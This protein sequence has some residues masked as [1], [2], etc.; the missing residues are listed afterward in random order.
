M[1]LKDF[2]MTSPTPNE[3]HDWVNQYSDMA[4]VDF[5][6]YNRGLEPTELMIA[7]ASKVRNP[8]SPPQN[9]TATKYGDHLIEATTII[10]DDEYNK[11]EVSGVSLGKDG[12]DYSVSVI[13]NSGTNNVTMGVTLNSNTIEI[14]LGTNSSG[15]LSTSIINENFI[16]NYDTFEDLVYSNI[17]YDTEVVTETDNT[18]TYTRGTD[19]EMDY[20]NGKIKVLSDSEMA[21][22]T[23]YAIDYYYSENQGYNIAQEVENVLADFT[24]DVYYDGRGLIDTAETKDLIGGKTGTETKYYELTCIDKSGETTSSTTISVDNCLEQFTSE[25]YV[26]LNWES[27]DRAEE[28]GV[29]G[30]T[31][32]LKE[33]LT[34]VDTNTYADK[35][36]DHIGGIPPEYNTTD[37]KVRLWHGS[38]EQETVLEFANRK[39][40]MSADSKLIYYLNSKDVD[41][42]AFGAEG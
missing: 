32:S 1:A 23:G 42:V 20:I 9:I 19:Y 29:Y 16:S 8:L 14:N 27:N 26:E 2:T 34:V 13:D 35:M 39:I 38:L 12:D 7:L 33:E 22:S 6:I 5:N 11:I 25:D 31:E 17:I 15:N 28:Y 24:A 37:L 18:S 41:L 36:K 21:D 4:I 30:R 40:L 10:G 3:W